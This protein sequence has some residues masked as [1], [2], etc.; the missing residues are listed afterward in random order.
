MK[1]NF[2]WSWYESENDNVHTNID[3]S[4]ADI[5]R[6]VLDHYLDVTNLTVDGESAGTLV[7]HWPDGELMPDDYDPETWS[8]AARPW[9]VACWLEDFAAN[10]LHRCDRFCIRELGPT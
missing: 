6:T 9:D 5:V 10:Q 3:A 2:I 4:L 7:V 1:N 8:V